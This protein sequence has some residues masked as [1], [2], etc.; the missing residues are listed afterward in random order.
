MRGV[1]DITIVSNTHGTAIV[2]NDNRLGIERPTRTGRG[3]AVMPDSDMTGKMA[4]RFLIEYVRHPPHAGENSDFFTVGR[5]NTR[6]FLAAVLEGIECK[7][8]K[9]GYIFIRRI[10]AKNAARL[11]QD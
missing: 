11:V 3:I 10:Y 6:T 1:N 9:T 5:G 4:Q 8:G 2:T 7:K